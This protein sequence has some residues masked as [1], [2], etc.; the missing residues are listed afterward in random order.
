MAMARKTTPL[1]SFLVIV[2]L[3]ILVLGLLALLL[4]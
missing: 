1:P 2:G 3:V 4:R